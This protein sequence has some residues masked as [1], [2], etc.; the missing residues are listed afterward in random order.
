MDVEA[1][2]A[3][4]SG[5]GRQRDEVEVLERAQGAEVEDRPEVDEEA[6]RALAGE[7]DPATGQRVRRL[8]GEVLIVG[9]AP[10]ADVDRRDR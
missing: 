9:G 7:D 8:I 4:D 10:D 5:H 1:L 6:V 3:V 2:Q